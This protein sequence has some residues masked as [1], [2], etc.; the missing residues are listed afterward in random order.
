MG[1]RRGRGKPRVACD[2]VAQC[3]RSDTWVVGVNRPSD[4]DRQVNKRDQQMTRILVIYYSQTGQLARAVKSMMAP[5]E[6]HPDVEVVWQRV[7]PASPF[8]FPWGFFSF[9][10]V[11]PESV[12]LD[13]PPLK[14]AE[15]DPDAHFDLVILAYQ[16]WF[17]SP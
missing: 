3:R 8:P 7:E 15:F 6:D 5:L 4:R 9:L 17:L 14:P 13:P 12:Y 11:F 16:V 1:E 2:P 10:D